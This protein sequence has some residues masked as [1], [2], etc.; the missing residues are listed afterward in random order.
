MF[1]WN[2][3]DVKK[4]YWNRSVPCLVPPLLQW[5]RGGKEQL[6]ESIFGNPSCRGGTKEKKMKKR[7]NKKKIKK[8]YQRVGF[9]HLGRFSPPPSTINCEGRGCVDR[10]IKGFCRRSEEAMSDDLR[11]SPV[12]RRFCPK[13]NKR[14]KKIEKEKKKQL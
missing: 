8:N 13:Q 10:N 1:C 5:R 4:F 9:L 12:C 3:E 7:D 6:G 2:L 14:K 11:G